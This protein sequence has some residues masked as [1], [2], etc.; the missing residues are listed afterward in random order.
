MYFILKSI[1]CIEAFVYDRFHILVL[2]NKIQET[3]QSQPPKYTYF[4]GVADAHATPY[5]GAVRTLQQSA[6]FL[7]KKVNL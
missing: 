6:R 3:V 4:G 2:N 7:R 5:G 1:V